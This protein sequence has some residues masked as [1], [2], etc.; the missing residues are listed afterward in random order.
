MT[1]SSA[2][3]TR[4]I[5]R[6]NAGE[7]DAFAVLLR[8]YAVRV[9][10]YCTA[11]LRDASLG[12]DAAQE[13]FLK[14]Y[15]GLKTFHGDSA[16]SS[17][18]YRIMVNHCRDLLRKAAR[19]KSESWEALLE[20]EGETAEAR[21]TGPADAAERLE[22]AETLR[23][24]LAELP[25]SYREI[26]LLRESQGLNYEELASVLG[27]SLDA[28]KSRLKRARQEIVS[29]SRHFLPQEGV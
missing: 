2:E 16:F 10:C 26:L 19:R 15:Q 29:R 21:L 1:E 5:H 23:R 20:R 28:V 25:E 22:H 3:D 14:A 27:C 24:A 13:I 7:K 11:T 8:K 9:R 12:E 18:L 17:W 6:V 4:T